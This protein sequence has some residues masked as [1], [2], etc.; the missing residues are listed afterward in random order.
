V[1]AAIVQGV[2]GCVLPGEMLLV[3]GPPGSG[4]STLMQALA[5]TLPKN[6]TMTVGARACVNV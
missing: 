6:L 4:C 2:S 3:I 1:E 5:G